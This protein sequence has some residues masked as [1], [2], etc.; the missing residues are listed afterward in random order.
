MIRLL[1]LVIL[2]ALNFGCSRSS[3]TRTSFAVNLSSLVA[4]LTF[5]GGAHI[6]VM[7]LDE[8]SFTAYDLTDT[9]VIELAR[10]EWKIYFV[11]FEG[12]SP[13]DGPY[14]CGVV[15]PVN[16]DEDQETVNINVST[17]NCTG[18]NTFNAM[19]VTKNPSAAGLWDSGV[20]DTALWAP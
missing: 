8:S 4:G 3:P 15:S 18:N 11:G 10:G 20:W 19:I 14:K 6:R 2:V 17:S 1:S 12:A 5:T 16:L 7:P 9:N 13:W